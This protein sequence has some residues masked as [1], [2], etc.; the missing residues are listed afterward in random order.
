MDSGCGSE[1][2]GSGFTQIQIQIQRS[3]RLY[4]CFLTQAAAGL[5]F[6]RDTVVDLG[7][8]CVPYSRTDFHQ[9]FRPTGVL[10]PS[11]KRKAQERGLCRPAPGPKG[12]PPD[13]FRG[14]QP[15]LE[16]AD[17]PDSCSRTRP[18]AVRS[19]GHHLKRA[20]PVQSHQNQDQIL[21]DDSSKYHKNLQRW[22]PPAP[23]RWT[24]PDLSKSGRSY[25]ISSLISQ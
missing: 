4:Q 3:Q 22:S 18:T 19:A 2:S 24:D 7:V 20:R 25:F 16:S 17:H 21:L 8:D 15:A 10:T 23:Q 13:R 6:S 1:V 14:L 11:A 9:L 12:A 5:R